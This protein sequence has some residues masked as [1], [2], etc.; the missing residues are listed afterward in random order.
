MRVC[1]AYS[2]LKDLNMGKLEDVD[3]DGNCGYSC[4]RL[5]LDDLSLYKRYEARTIV[6]KLCREIF[7]CRRMS[8]DIFC[9]SMYSLCSVFFAMVKFF[10][11]SK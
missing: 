6:T 5:G 2:E 10:M 3:K 8:M 7:E 1:T 4:I 11:F 9:C